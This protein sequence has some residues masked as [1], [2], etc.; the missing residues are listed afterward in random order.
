MSAP[1]T[2]NSGAR[3]PYQQPI[4]SHLGYPVKSCASFR[5]GLAAAV[6]PICQISIINIY[7]RS[8]RRGIDLRSRARMVDLPLSDQEASDFNAHSPVYLSP[9]SSGWRSDLDWHGGSWAQH[10]VDILMAAEFSKAL[11]ST[12][13]FFSLFRFRL[14]CLGPSRVPTHSTYVCDP[15]LIALSQSKLVY[16]VSAQLGPMP[17]P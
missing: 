3:S 16:D 2:S 13:R 11:K 6:V 12:L 14:L 17:I 7:M 15:M 8:L 9:K 4:Y 1:C 5:L 10:R